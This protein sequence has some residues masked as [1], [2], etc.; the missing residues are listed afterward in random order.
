MTENKGILIIGGG[1]SGLTLAH[2]LFKRNIQATI[3]EAA[4]R[5]GGRIHTQI[6]KLDTPLELGATWF[7]DMHCLWYQIWD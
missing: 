5:L 1:L 2:L 7:S 4:P 3:L 6:G